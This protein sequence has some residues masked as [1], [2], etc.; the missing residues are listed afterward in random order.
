MQ[1][2]REGLE[3]QAD[4]FAAYRAAQKHI[5]RMGGVLEQLARECVSLFPQLTCG[6]RPIAGLRAAEVR[7]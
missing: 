2:L 3:P 4:G 7:Y 5:D 6:K 1:E